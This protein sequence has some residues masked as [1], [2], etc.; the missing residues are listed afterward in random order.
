[1]AV[2][3]VRVDSVN[4]EKGSDLEKKQGFESSG[5]TTGIYGL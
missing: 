4:E 3:R 2:S 5:S 1:M